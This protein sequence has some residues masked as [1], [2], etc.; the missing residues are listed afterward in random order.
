MKQFTFLKKLQPL[1]IVL[2]LFP[3]VHACT[4]MSFYPAYTPDVM[5]RNDSVLGEWYSTGLL[6]KNDTMR[7]FFSFPDS[8]DDQPNAYTYKLEL[9]QAGN[10]RHKVR[11]DVHFMML[12]DSLYA[13][14]YPKETEGKQNNELVAFHVL[15][16]H[17]FVKVNPEPVLQLNWVSLVWLNFILED[18]PQA[19]A[20]EDNGDYI[21]LTA[22]T[23]ELLEFYSKHHKN[24][25]MFSEGLSYEL[26]R[27]GP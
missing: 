10:T 24:P 15:P 12:E 6:N 20:H 23:R 3:L 14:F 17:T 25:E 26:Y 19:V 21:L 8:I 22:P 7:W 11:F 9:E 5:V 16:V 13:D 4:V 27:Y 18:K 2:L 1:G